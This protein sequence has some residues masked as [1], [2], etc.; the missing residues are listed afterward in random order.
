MNVRLDSLGPLLSRLPGRIAV[1]A[2]FTALRNQLFQEWAGSPPH[3][4]SIAMPRPQGLGVRPR[5]LRPTDLENGQRV[6][7]GPRRNPQRCTGC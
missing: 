5:D 3:L 7:A 1:P 2:V 4:A 6:L